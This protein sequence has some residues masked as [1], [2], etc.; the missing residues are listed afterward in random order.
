MVKCTEMRHMRMQCI[1]GLLSPSLSEGLGTRLG[2]VLISDVLY[3]RCKE[4]GPVYVMFII[5]KPFVISIN[6]D[7]IKVS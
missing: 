3:F 5:H 2:V 4:V 6:P 1:P 7:D